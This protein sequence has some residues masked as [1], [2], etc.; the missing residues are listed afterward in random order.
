VN[1][2]FFNNLFLVSK[3]WVN[4]I[5]F[6]PFVVEEKKRLVVVFCYTYLHESI[7]K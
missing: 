5:S 3:A 1:K 4:I 7:Y 2:I 6:T